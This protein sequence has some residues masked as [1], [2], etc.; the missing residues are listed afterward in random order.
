MGLEPELQQL[1]AGAQIQDETLFSSPPPLLPML[2]GGKN[3][4][5]ARGRY[6][7]H[8]LCVC[9]FLQCPTIALLIEHENHKRNRDCNNQELE[10]VSY[11]NKK[12]KEQKLLEFD[13]IGF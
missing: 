10:W 5:L 12:V 4:V 2:N 9:I 7:I 3:L 1:F 11:L 13:Q 6:G 8:C